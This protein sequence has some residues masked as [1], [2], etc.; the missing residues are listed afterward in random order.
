MEDDLLKLQNEVKALQEEQ[1]EM[2][3]R[4]KVVY[5]WLTHI[6]KRLPQRIAL[7]P[8]AKGD[9]PAGKCRRSLQLLWSPGKILPQTWKQRSAVSG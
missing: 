3:E 7:P 5:E 6:D 9:P 1:R 8:A 4:L 2:G